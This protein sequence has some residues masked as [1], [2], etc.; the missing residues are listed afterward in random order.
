MKTLLILFIGGG[1]GASSRHFFS[2]W[3]NRLGVQSPYPILG[4]NLLGC[5]LIGLMT[6]LLIHHN[7]SPSRLFIITG[8]LGGFTTYSSYILDLLNLIEK[9]HFTDVFIYLIAHL[10]GG[11]LCCAIGL[12][13]G[14]IAI[15]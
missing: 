11:L 14:K 10:M 9:Q 1:I 5:F 8:I 3:L 13:V 12:I 4:V 7:Q 6:A 15:T 2:L